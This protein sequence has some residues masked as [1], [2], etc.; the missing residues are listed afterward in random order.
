M[1]PL[2]LLGRLFPVISYFSRVIF[3]MKSMEDPHPVFG[4]VPELLRL[5]NN[6]S[7][8]LTPFCDSALPFA[9]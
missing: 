5:A 7:H 6:E 1:K 8:V 2:M 3:F 4:G 9:D